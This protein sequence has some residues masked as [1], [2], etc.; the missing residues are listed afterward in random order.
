MVIE[1]LMDP[2]GGRYSFVAVFDHGFGT[3]SEFV[4]VFVLGFGT[5]CEFVA[6]FDPGLGTESEF[7]AVYEYG[8]GAVYGYEFDTG[9]GIATKCV[10]PH[11][12]N[13]AGE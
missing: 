7:V 8:F 9:F 5:E 10:D 11:R 1:W 2:S 6:V 3:E 4:A 13:S 12:F